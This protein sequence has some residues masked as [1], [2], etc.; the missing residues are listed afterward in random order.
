MLSG[1]G[2][3]LKAIDELEEFNSKDKEQWIGRHG[4]N[5]LGELEWL[6]NF[7]DDRQ[8]RRLRSCD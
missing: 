1:A 2:A 7:F 3:M 4:R 6:L 5:G 8:V